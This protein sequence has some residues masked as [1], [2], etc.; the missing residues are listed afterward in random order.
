MRQKMIPQEG[1]SRRHWLVSLAGSSLYVDLASSQGPLA[2]LTPCLHEAT[3]MTSD[4]KT[5]MEAYGKAGFQVVEPWLAKVD[6]Y[7]AQSSPGEVRRIM[8]DQGLRPVSAGATPTN[9]FFPRLPERQQRIDA[10]KKRLELCQEL[11]IPQITSPSAVFQTDVKPEDFEAAIDLVREVGEIAKSFQIKIALEFIKGSAFLGCLGSVM[12][13]CRKANHPNVRPML[14]T[15]H[16]Y[17]GV[18][19]LEDLDLLQQGELLHVHINDVP[20]GVPRE[21]LTDFHRILPGDGIIPLQAILSRLRTKGYN[22]YVSVEL[23]SR[24]LWQE[25]PQVVARKALASLKRIIG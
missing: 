21:L 4:F 14:D 22:S 13:L 10:L 2:T 7:L 5:A 19:K 16:F 1:S 18:S 25:D 3:T 15:F 17:A 9:I 20:A 24:D 23:F 6:E 12:D 11:G 8:K